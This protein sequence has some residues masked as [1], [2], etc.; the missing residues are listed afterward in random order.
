MKIIESICEYYGASSEEDLLQNYFQELNDS[1]VPC[2]CT[3][4][5]EEV[6]D[7]EP[8]LYKMDCPICGAEKTVHSVVEIL[9]GGL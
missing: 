1:V 5:G 3:A 9:L 7:G 8:D 2:F 4:C 6:Q